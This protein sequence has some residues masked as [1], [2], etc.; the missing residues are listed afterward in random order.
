MPSREI[1]SK[2]LES[3]SPIMLTMQDY[4]NICKRELQQK[5]T[6]IFNS[7]A[8]ISPGISRGLNSFASDFGVN[9][10]NLLAPLQQCFK[11]TYFFLP[12]CS[13]ILTSQLPGSFGRISVQNHHSFRL[14][15]LGQLQPVLLWVV[16]GSS[17]ADRYQGRFSI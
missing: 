9:P 6:C 4:C 5:E 8:L 11:S 1:C 7:L 15:F 2:Q 17:C 12:R 10:K 13:E 14:G 16:P 3:S